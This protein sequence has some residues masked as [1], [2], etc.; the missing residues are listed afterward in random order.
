MKQLKYS[1]KIKT[2]TKTKNTISMEVERMVT[3]RMKKTPYKTLN[4]KKHK[5]GELYIRTSHICGYRYIEEKR[6]VEIFLINGLT[7]IICLHAKQEWPA[8]KTRLSEESSIV[9]FIIREN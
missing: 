2:K 7:Q 5:M 9:K 1:K 6:T 8:L 4:P 3:K